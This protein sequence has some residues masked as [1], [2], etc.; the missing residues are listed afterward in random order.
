[1]RSS[2]ISFDMLRQKNSTEYIK[3][4]PA[5]KRKRRAPFDSQSLNDTSCV[6]KR[7]RVSRYMMDERHSMQ[8]CSYMMSSLGFGSLHHHDGPCQRAAAAAATHERREHAVH[9]P[10]VSPPFSVDAAPLPPPPAAGNGSNDK[11]RNLRRETS[12]SLVAKITISCSATDR[13]GAA[14]IV[15]VEPRLKS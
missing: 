15:H 8:K 9:P 1:M 2:T 4:K 6:L 5:R 10:R 3:A 12:V 11:C 13:H 14:G 7:N